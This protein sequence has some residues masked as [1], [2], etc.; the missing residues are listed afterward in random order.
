MQQHHQAQL[1]QAKTVKK[2][3]QSS[4]KIIDHLTMK[5]VNDFLCSH[6]FTVLLIYI[7]STQE[8]NQVQHHQ[9]QSLVIDNNFSG[10]NQDSQSSSSNS[11]TANKNIY[12]ISN[13][14]STQTYP[15]TGLKLPVVMAADEKD[16][17]SGANN[18]VFINNSAS[19]L[20]KLINLNSSG[21]NNVIIAQPANASSN[22]PS[23][24]K[25]SEKMM[26][27][28]G[29]V[30]DNAL[31]SSNDN[32]SSQANAF[33][34]N[35]AP[36]PAAP[37][38]SS[39]SATKSS[40]QSTQPQK[41]VLNY[42]LL[43]SYG[44]N[45]PSQSMD[46]KKMAQK[47]PSQPQQQPPQAPQYYNN[48]ATSSSV[49]STSFDYSMSQN[50]RPVNSMPQQQQQPGAKSNF[51]RNLISTEN[52]NYPQYQQYPQNNDPNVMNNNAYQQQPQQPSSQFHPIP[53]T[54]QSNQ[55][56]H[57]QQMTSSL[58]PA[59][60]IPPKM[61]NDNVL[62]KALLQTAPKNAAQQPQTVQP[63]NMQQ[64][65]MP[66][67]IIM[68]QQ[69]QQPVMPP[70][71][72]PSVI[73]A[74]Q[75][76]NMIQQQPQSIVDNRFQEQQS[77]SNGANNTQTLP[78]KSKASNKQT[79]MNDLK[80]K[81][82][83]SSQSLEKSN[84]EAE[85]V[86]QPTKK[87]KK[88][89]P[90]VSGSAVPVATNIQA[91]QA[92]P[93]LTNPSSFNP[94][95]AGTSLA[96]VQHQEENSAE[97][98]NDK[99][100]SMYYS[101][102]V[103]EFKQL[104]MFYMAQPSFS[105]IYK[106][107]KSSCA[108]FIV[109]FL[110][111]SDPTII[112]LPERRHAF[113]MQ[114]SN[115]FKIN[116]DPFVPFSL[117]VDPVSSEQTSSKPKTNNLIDVCLHRPHELLMF[118]DDLDETEEKRPIKQTF[119]LCGSGEVKLP[120]S[121]KDGDKIKDSGKRV[122]EVLSEPMVVDTDEAPSTAMTASKPNGTNSQNFIIEELL[123]KT[124]KKEL[125]VP[126]NFNPYSFDQ[127]SAASPVIDMITMS[128]TTNDEQPNTDTTNQD[129]KMIKTTFKL[130]N[131]AANNIQQTMQKL[132]VLLSI[133]NNNSNGF[134][135]LGAIGASEIKK[136]ETALKTSKFISIF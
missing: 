50:M 49:P 32:Y 3:Q 93:V 118:N 45:P 9:T 106:P 4:F 114:H 134:W 73:Q 62:L 100:I 85:Q 5:Q 43:N 68:Q 71:P 77:Q 69:Q 116:I 76:V 115:A 120:K 23:G 55:V 129:K 27:L 36:L 48:S 7:K 17:G 39:H 8:N 105:T 101:K 98:S 103:N 12:L 83:E 15:N 38:S 136:Q 109:K 133:N 72:A 26:Q 95:T 11:N 110:N 124:V 25:M 127:Q 66:S 58:V 20:K 117:T 54:D 123:K 111:K 74:P 113:I 1:E 70:P 67:Q 19:N 104:G 28:D 16:G 61:N 29:Q 31:M 59:Q 107:K 130:S 6:L 63:H 87:R 99:V 22:E 65:S 92:S 10:S 102:L 47:Q 80:N 57:Q 90:V 78:K 135:D 81:I 86:A 126:T 56:Y 84:G 40:Y 131:R 2:K 88:A 112:N 34:S 89:A 60:Q 51:I 44:I 94:Q 96:V 30:D 33:Q 21:E 125:S 132:A 108:N 82:I 122:D 41:V 91:T 42:E 24:S 35:Q 128:E 18:I 52:N 64:T 46:D 13:L 121:E 14:S 79:L 119:R 53:Q 75:S 97:S 37:P